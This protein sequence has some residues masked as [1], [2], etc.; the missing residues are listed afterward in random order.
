MYPYR[1]S[2]GLRPP[3]QAMGVRE[4]WLVY[5]WKQS[6]EVRSF[7]AGNEAVYFIGDILKSEV[8]PGLALAVARIF[9]T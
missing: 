7:E 9:S 4:L 1:P 3:Y 5:P 2:P 8:L 6:I